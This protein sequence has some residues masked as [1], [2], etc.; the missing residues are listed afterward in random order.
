MEN[1]YSL[2]E[3]M[4][5]SVCSLILLALAAALIFSNNFRD[6]LLGGEGEASVLGL[7]SVKG[8]AIVLIFALFL[9]TEVYI[10][11]G[12]NSS[13]GSSDQQSDQNPGSAS[14]P[15][16]TY[17]LTRC[18]GD[19]ATKADLLKTYENQLAQCNSQT[20]SDRDAIEGLKTTLAS[21]E[22]DQERLL[23]K[24][25]R[26]NIDI[27]RFYGAVDFTYQPEKKQEAAYRVLEVLRILN[28]YSGVPEQSPALAREA[29]IKFQ[30]LRNILPDEPSKQGLLGRTTFLKI[31]EEYMEYEKTVAQS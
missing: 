16:C 27:Q 22:K 6:D 31:V 21:C 13:P 26:L 15:N 29:L 24:I 8:V 5:V 23:T 20:E 9:G 30:Q 4:V 10:L 7:M 17:E 28:H 12:G 2:P 14:A 19:L 1:A 3:L 11:Q 25:D 18:K